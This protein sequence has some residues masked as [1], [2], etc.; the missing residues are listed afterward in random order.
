MALTLIPKESL[1]R[2]LA[3]HCVRFPLQEEVWP[4]FDCGGDLVSAGSGLARGS[5]ARSV[6]VLGAH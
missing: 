6:R 2:L 4:A 1:A 5:F 3:H